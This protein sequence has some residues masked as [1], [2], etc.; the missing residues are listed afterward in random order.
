[1]PGFGINDIHRAI[2]ADSA[3]HCVRVIEGGKVT[4]YA[5]QVGHPG[6]ADGARSE[7]SF[8]FPTDMS[9]TP[10]G[11]LYLSEGSH[12]R[13]IDGA[14]GTV[15]TIAGSPTVGADAGGY[16]DGTG[17]EA[18]FKFP[19]GIAMR[20]DGAIFVSDTGNQRVRQV[21]PGG[22][23]TTI[24]GKGGQGMAIGTG[25]N[26]QFSQ[27]VGIVV[28]ADGSLLVVDYNLSRIFRIVRSGP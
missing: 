24:A 15:T 4:V 10:A 12:L 26:A 1:L 19:S 27:P 7:A 2:G 23:V 11:V 9:V 21:T 18:R 22:V 17:P 6:N 8:F 5:G 13:R 20:P 28:D 16:A 25:A 14:A 3:N